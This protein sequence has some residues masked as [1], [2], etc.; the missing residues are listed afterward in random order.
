M[1]ESL[2]KEIQNT[3]DNLISKK[4]KRKSSGKGKSK[5]QIAK[6]LSEIDTSKADVKQYDSF[7][8]LL[9]DLDFD[10]TEELKA[11]FFLLDESFIQGYSENAKQYQEILHELKSKINDLN[12]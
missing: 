9:I 1:T 10:L 11:L 2:K 12:I 5:N 4:K 3:I 7:V 6:E 8:D